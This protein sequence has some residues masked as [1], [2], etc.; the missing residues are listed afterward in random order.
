MKPLT[1]FLTAYAEA[2]PAAQPTDYVK[3]LFQSAFGGEHLVADPAG[4]LERLVR[5]AAGLSSAQR[6][7]PWVEP[8]PGPIC[9][10]NLSVLQAV[11]PESLNKMFCLSAA[12][13]DGDG[14][15]RFQEG[16]EALLNLTGEKPGLF[17]FSEDA[18]R[19]YLTA[20]RAKGGGAV[21]HSEAF[22]QAYGPAY[23]VVRK[24]YAVLL[25]VIGA[26][27]KLLTE[28]ERVLVALDGPCGGGKT[29]SARR[30]AALFDCNVFHADDFYLP[31]ELRT[32]ERLLEPGGNMHRERLL[33]EVLL[34]VQAGETARPRRFDHARLA[35]GEAQT[36]RP[37]RLNIIEGS[38]SLHPALR[39]AYDLRVFLHIPPEEQLE[40][41]R[42]R[43]SPESF[44]QF[45]ERW[46]PLEERY[47]AA[48]KVAQCADLVISTAM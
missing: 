23:R 17:G 15:A 33:E 38:Y 36:V 35:P 11:S 7:Q 18:L 31:A 42:H 4:T 3:L 12:E 10:V 1:D 8:L 34:P 22:R 46:I 40:R 13:K 48:C 26:I 28:K 37:R 20:Y 9:R 47:F 44:A 21:R 41:L 45:V 14:E 2:H 24:E 32:T 30:L 43:E 19:A 29:E 39:D 27:E 5:E 16:I 6:A 25:P